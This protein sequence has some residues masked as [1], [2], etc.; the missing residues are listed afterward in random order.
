MFDGDFNVEYAAVI[1]L[2]VIQRKS[3]YVPQTN[4]HRFSFPKS[5][6]GEPGVL[7][8]TKDLE[9]FPPT[10]REECFLA[11]L[12]KIPSLSAGGFV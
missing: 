3:K 8:I 7:D 1:P 9:I 5:L 6:L 4:S 11:G 10:D 12:R 2:E